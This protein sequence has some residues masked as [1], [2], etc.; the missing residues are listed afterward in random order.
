MNKPF[1][2]RSFV[3]DTKA[4]GA[5]A[6][7]FLLLVLLLK[8]TEFFLLRVD[9]PNG[10]RLL[11]NACVY[12]VVVASWAV[13]ALGVLFLLLRLIGP[14]VAKVV[15]ALLLSLL[16]LAEVGLTAYCLHNGFL[17]G[18]ELLLRPLSESLMAIRGAM[19]VVLPVLL[20]LLVV[21]GAFG[22]MLWRG[23]RPTNMAWAALPVAV[24]MTL[25]SIVFDLSHLILNGH[26]NYI[27]NKTAFFVENCAQSLQAERNAAANVQDYPYDEA[28]LKALLET[29]PEWGTPEDLHYPL[30]RATVADTFLSPYFSPAEGQ[31]NVVLVLVES[32]GDEFMGYGIMPFVDSLAA[33]GLYWRNCLSTTPRSYGAI[34]ALTGSVGGPRSFQFGSMPNHNSIFSLLKKSGYYTC[35]FFGGDYTFDCIYDYLMAQHV[36]QLSSFYQEKEQYGQTHWWGAGDDYLFRRTMEE[37]PL[38]NPQRPF[39]GLVTTLSMHDE[40][41][42]TDDK[43]EAA[44]VQRAQ[45]VSSPKAGPSLSALYPSC[46]FTDDCLRQ[47]FHKFSQ[48]S[49]F[50]NTIFIVTGDHATGRQRGDKLSFHHVPLIIWSPLVKEHAVFDHLVTHNDLAPAL[51]GLLVD[52]YGVSPH[53]T[54]H[55]LGSGLGPTPK[56]MLVLNYT[57]VLDEMV[58]HNLFYEATTHTVYTIGKDLALTP[59]SDKEK[60]TVCQRQ[61][62]GM[63]YLYEYTYFANRL[64]AHPVNDLKYTLIYKRLL[65]DIECVAPHDPPS[66]AGMV[67]IPILRQMELKNTAGYTTARVTV[68]ADVTVHD[69]MKMDQ[70]PEIRFFVYGDEELMEA[71]R[72][73]RFV[74]GVDLPNP[75]NGHL[76]LSKEFALSASKPNKIYVE[77]QTPYADEDHV[78]DASITLSGTVVTIEYGK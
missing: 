49:D 46:I 32:L 9:E 74:T 26:E 71:T 27:V 36:D 45:K 61:L 6:G 66:V 23:S 51:Y 12:N 75:G 60:E 59:C 44:Y 56:T 73:P 55:W 17:L 38:A 43:L 68:E 78:P 62:E 76:L 7:I 41:D 64:T 4:Y 16:L 35:S 18:G 54:V 8:V 19:G 13:L 47:F 69:S 40:L 29:H 1:F 65:N 3:A 58:Y 70:Y 50:A 39:M 31:P 57:H 11:L 14:R 72:L 2:S 15:V 30:E 77:L 34:P 22:L 37:L 52:R 5:V 42:L 25:L 28:L 10:T 21:G 20:A 67:N 48:R 53:P 24:V 33:T 63:S